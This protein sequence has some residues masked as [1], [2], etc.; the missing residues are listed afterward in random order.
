MALSRK[1]A[2]GTPF[3]P[4]VNVNHHFPLETAMCKVVPLSFKLHG[5]LKVFEFENQLS[6]TGITLVGVQT[7]KLNPSNKLN[8]PPSPDENPP[9]LATPQGPLEA[10]GSVPQRVQRVQRPAAA[11]AAATGAAAGGVGEDEVSG[12]GWRWIAWL[13][14]TEGKYI[15][16]RLKMME[17]ER[18]IYMM[19][20]EDMEAIACISI[21]LSI[22][23]L[24]MV[25]FK[26]SHISVGSRL[27]LQQPS[28]R[29]VLA[30]GCTYLCCE[31]G[32]VPTAR[33][34][35]TAGSFQETLRSRI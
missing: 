3:N 34:A 10:S 4:L 11:A 24:D 2:P 27:N 13:W 19:I 21:V 26:Q 18:K 23:S 35:E 16:G 6:Y 9:P 29:L 31:G 28:M 8:P 22:Q 15:N 20:Y 32:K 5:N 17:D 7:I 30:I 25:A 33:G 14:N 1:R 12:S